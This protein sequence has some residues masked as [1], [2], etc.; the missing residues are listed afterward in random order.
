MANPILTDK[1]MTEIESMFGFVN[2]YCPN[3]ETKDWHV[4]ILKKIKDNLHTVNVNEWIECDHA[5]VIMSLYEQDKDNIPC[6]RC[7]KLGIDWA[8]WLD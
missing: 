4:E 1:E 2:D 7:G 6:R 3:E 5:P 8:V